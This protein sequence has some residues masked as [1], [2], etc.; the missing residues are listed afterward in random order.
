ML[1]PRIIIADTDMGYLIP[2]QLRF[3]EAFFEKID[4]EIITEKSYF[5][6]AFASPQKAEILIVSQDLYDASLQKH[7]IGKIFLMMEQYEEGQVDDL[8][9]HKVFKYTS[10]N[11]VFNEIIG[12]SRAV[13]NEDVGRQKESQIVVVY[14]AAGGAGKTTVALGMAAC[15]TKNYKKVLYINASWLQS[16]QRMLGNP[17]AI[18]SSD[19]YVS[20][21]KASPSIYE[22]VKYV[23]RKELF[24]YLPPFKAALMS[25]GLNYSVYAAIA[26]SAK[27]SNE[28][29][30]IIVDAD[31]QFDDE[32][33]SLI[34]LADKVVIVTKQ[35]AASVYATNSLVANINEIGTEKFVFVCNDFR[36]E[37]ENALIS[38]AVSPKF[39]VSEF[40]EHISN[41]DGIK[42]EELALCSGMNK[43]SILVI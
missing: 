19:I 21:S 4:L 7:N 31:S 33:A 2:L 29:D 35:N 26:L 41:Y 15:L 11:E 3:I 38:P 28:Y 30:Y 39:F 42:A 14:S 17:T 27:K 9:V 13:L 37:E 32:K 34:S 43:A 24:T 1:K 12:K 36:K 16:F 6:S 8:N 22:E 40:I 5:D 20:L 10:I 18:A 25:L 23:L